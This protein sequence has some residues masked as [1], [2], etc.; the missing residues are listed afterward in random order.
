MPNLSEIDRVF[1]DEWGRAVSILISVLGDFD[2]AED[3]VQDAFATALERWPDDGLPDNPGAW[4]V[5]TAR[6]R[7]IDRIRRDQTLQRK[8]ELLGRLA[9]LPES[10]EEMSTIPDERLALVFTCC[11]PA[12]G[13]EARVALTLREVGGLATGEIARA[14]L[15]AEPTMAQRLVRA[16]RKI[17]EAGIPFRVPPEEVL[18][19]RLQSVLAVLYLVFNEGYA[20][21]RGDDLVRR[22]LCD[23]A[24]RLAKLLAVLM[25]DEAEALGLL[26]LMLF[27][28]SRREARTGPEGELILLE[29][30]DRSSW[31]QARIDEGRRVL[32]RA[33]RLRRIGPYQLQA[34]IAAVHAETA[35]DWTAVA[36]LYEHLARLAPS[37]IV[38][39]NRAVAIAM[40]GSVDEGL[41]LIAQIE[42]LENYH[43]LHAARADLLRRLGRLDE[44][45]AA[46][47]QAL[48]LATNP[49]ERAFLERRL[50][51]V[52]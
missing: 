40:A 52:P 44:A 17:R 15:T 20:A 13:S 11:H 16:K 5:T 14:F 48:T 41:D 33:A 34:V 24:I 10:E 29:D 3:A 51:E 27:H 38:D 22:E 39:L 18:P 7:A 50:S 43:L 45:A 19:D 37:P 32:E 42:G 30:Q 8:T 6:N 12:L 1:R 47:R 4:I 25:P 35:T 21:T 23:E 31:N 46:Y 9:E 49:V 28:D 2:L 26:A 36:A